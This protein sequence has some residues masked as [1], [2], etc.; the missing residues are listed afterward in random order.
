VALTIIC[1]TLF[2]A[3]PW[4]RISA[5]RNVGVAVA[6]AVTATSGI[7]L[8]KDGLTN[9]AVCV[10]PG[11]HIQWQVAQGLLRMGLAPGD[12][13]AVLGHTT[14]AD[15]WAHLAGFRVTGDIP[16]ED[17]QSY[18]LAS[19]DTREQ[20]ASRLQ[21]HGI[22]ALVIVGTPLVAANWRHIG[23]TGYYVQTLS[24]HQ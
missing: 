2:G 13:V 9:L 3:V 14:I 17:M 24:L 15:Y 7:A 6:L 19:S 18:W 16:L 23:D 4:S 11:N 12:Q 10:R 21:A 1:L 22:K 5:G 20:I 8:V